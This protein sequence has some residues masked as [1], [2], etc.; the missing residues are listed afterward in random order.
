MAGTAESVWLDAMSVHPFASD[1][2]A[3]PTRAV[4]KSCE[5]LYRN[6]VDRALSPRIQWSQ[7]P[8]SSIKGEVKKK[9]TSFGWNFSCFAAPLIERNLF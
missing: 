3:C 4:E 2:M 1:C 5:L 9:H 8:R 7:V 6:C